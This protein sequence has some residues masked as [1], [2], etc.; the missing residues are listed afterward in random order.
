MN[1]S[2]IFNPFVPSYRRNP[3]LQLDRLRA[4][5]P[6]HRS[7]ALQA[8]ILTRYDD[9][10]RV[11]RDHDTFSSDARQAGGQ[12]A[13]ALQEQRANSPLGDTRSV[14]A[15]D[16]PEHT[17]L[18]GIVN[19]AFTPRS[20]ELL[21]PRMEEIVASLLD[22]LPD[23]GEWDLM[24]GLAQPLPVIV[25]A[26]LL[27]I[28]PEDRAQFKVWSQHIALTTD[29]MQSQESI[30]S[31]RQ[32]TSEL[33]E[34]FGGFIEDRRRQPR[35]DLISALVAA[36][37]EGRRLT[38]AE[39]LAFAILLLVAGNETTTNLIGSGMRT[40]LAHP[41]AAA[42]LRAQPERIPAAIEEMLRYD[43]PVQGIVRFATREV[44][45]GDKTLRK[46]D[47]IMGMTGA[48]NRDPD[49]FPNPTAFDLDRGDTRHLAFGMGIHYCVGAPLARVEGAIA[50]RALLERWPSIEAA[51]D[52]EMGG[53]FLIRGPVRLPLAVARGA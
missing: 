47:V 45:V 10:L 34:Y 16:P 18:R 13:A 27:G 40:L 22:E 15:S 52:V 48:A 43:S 21:R 30:E 14:L 29:I 8:W 49:Q 17:F 28:P 1:T 2:P 6:V 19:R 9:V 23:T 53:T 32:A 5:E 44:E 36:E 26:E 38:G 3:Y 11:L 35:E 33:V 37:T 31:I 46:G 39:V 41:E 25:I 42:A 51:G 50:F 4:A 12:I 20:V 24:D 7:D